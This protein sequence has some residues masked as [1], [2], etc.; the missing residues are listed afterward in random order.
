MLKVIVNALLFHQP[1][2]KVEVRLVVLDTILARVERPAQRLGDIGD[3]V[4]IQNQ[5]DDVRHGLLLKYLAVAG[6]GEEPQPRPNDGLVAKIL[7]NGFRDLAELDYVAVEVPLAIVGERHRNRNVLPDELVELDLGILAHQLQTELEQPAQLLAALERAE[8]QFAFT[9]GT[10]NGD[11][12]GHDELARMRGRRVRRGKETAARR[13]AATGTRAK[14]ARAR[15]NRRRGGRL[16]RLRCGCRSYGVG[17]A[18]FH[19][20]H[21][22]SSRRSSAIDNR[23]RP[24]IRGPECD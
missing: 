2:E 4:L 15:L 23:C 8:N 13:P 7:V 6:A 16:R 22:R 11:G 14:S 21:Y 10:R 20:R 5:L 3:A 9:Q 24:K 12:L 19:P 1:A 18:R 17:L